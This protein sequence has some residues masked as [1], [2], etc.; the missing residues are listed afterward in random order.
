[1]LSHLPA[2]CYDFKYAQIIGNKS[3]IKL[4]EMTHAS[5]P[6]LLDPKAKR[7]KE[8]AQLFGSKVRPFF[9]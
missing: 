8:I 3:P 6:L 4:G 5:A 7:I 2:T 9:R 1:M